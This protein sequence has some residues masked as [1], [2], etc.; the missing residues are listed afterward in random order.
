MTILSRTRCIKTV[1][2]FFNEIN[3]NEGE[4]IM[5][6]NVDIVCDLSWGDTGQKAK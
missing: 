2:I 1:P 4:V 3:L 5:I 6:K